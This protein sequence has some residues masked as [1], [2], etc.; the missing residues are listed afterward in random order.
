MKS[1]LVKTIVGNPCFINILDYSCNSPTIYIPKE[2]ETLKQ[3]ALKE[4][5]IEMGID[6]M[7]TKGGKKN[8][9]KRIRKTNNRRNKYR[10][11]KR[12]SKKRMN[13]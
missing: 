9:H 6:K 8:R 10:S 3:Y 7:V 13:I 4:S 2:Q 11:R 12:K 1:E 5:D